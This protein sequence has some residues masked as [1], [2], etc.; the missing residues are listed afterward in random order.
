MLE[1][2]HDNY[3]RGDPSA[4]WPWTGARHYTGYG[5]IADEHNQQH[6]ATRIAYELAH[7]PIPP[8]RHVCH[9]C[10]NPPC[11]NPAHLFVGRPADNTADAVRKG[12]WAVGTKKVNAKLT[13]AD[14]R[15]IRA[16]TLT[17][18][19]LALKFNVSKQLICFIRTRRAWKHIR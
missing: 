7:G 17:Y 6:R 9:R 12:R 4:C 3:E 2:F 15:A 8:G 10:D 11:V 13:D 14:V 5:V 19:E 16:S 18:K 1:R